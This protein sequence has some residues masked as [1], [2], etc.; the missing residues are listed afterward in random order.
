MPTKKLEYTKIT[1][2]AIKRLARRAGAIRLSSLVYEEIRLRLREFLEREISASIVRVNSTK[3]RTIMVEHV[4]PSLKVSMY[5]AEMAKY[6]CSSPKKGEKTTAI[7]EIKRLQGSGCLLLPLATFERLVREIV[8]DIDPTLRISAD[9]FLLFQY[10][11][12]NKMVHLLEGANRSTLHA[13]RLGIQ[14]RDIQLASSL[15]GYDRNGSMEVSRP[16]A[17]VPK[18]DFSKGIK[19]V[20]HEVYNDR[21]VKIT[22]NALSQVNFIVNFLAAT[23]AQ[24]ARDLTSLS[25]RSTVSSQDVQSAVYNIMPGE[26]AKHAVEEG[27]KALRNLLNKKI[28]KA[29]P[30]A[31]TSDLL[32][33]CIKLHTVKNTKTGKKSVS[34]GGCSTR[35][36]SNATVYLSAVLEYFTAELMELSGNLADTD[37]TARNIFMAISND[38]EMNSLIK[39]RLGLGILGAGVVPY[40]NYRIQSKEDEDEDE[41][42][43]D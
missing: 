36:S 13:G 31:L 42:E 27:N 9:A 28:K 12:E 6:K 25:N 2:N 26:L 7:K 3:M 11:A 23:L 35:V 38:D 39:N 43:E 17:T 37:I 29:F 5:S 20:L 14:P 34:K 30:T 40:I 32:K 22:F 4:E 1:N 41:E 33:Q 10:S 18:V 15:E 21:N 8:Q 24:N 19:M 16:S